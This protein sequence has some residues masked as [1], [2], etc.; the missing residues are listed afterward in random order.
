MDLLQIY[1]LSVFCGLFYT[2]KLSCRLYGAA[3]D[4]FPT[5]RPQAPQSKYKSKA[6]HSIKEF[7][8]ACVPHKGEGYLPEV[9]ICTGDYSSGHQDH[10]I[11]DIFHFQHLKI[12][13]TYIVIGTVSYQLLFHSQFNIREHE[14]IEESRKQVV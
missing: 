13:L 3:S 11:R 9:Y 10:V 7:D 2:W 6:I 1:F 14:N 12:C 5:P 8:A 4:Y